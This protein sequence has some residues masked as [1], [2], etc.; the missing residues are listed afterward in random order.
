MRPL[1]RD[2]GGEATASKYAIALLGYTFTA[3]MF[4]QK[5]ISGNSWE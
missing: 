1:H 3:L 5:Y 2:E 4:D